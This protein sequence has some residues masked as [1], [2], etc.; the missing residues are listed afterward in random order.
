MYVCI[1]LRVCV[2]QLACNIITPSTAKHIEPIKRVQPI[3][4]LIIYH[5][6]N[7]DIE[8]LLCYAINLSPIISYY[9]PMAFP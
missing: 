5:N 1:R 7:V 6:T 4:K 9:S 8:R 3:G 2:F